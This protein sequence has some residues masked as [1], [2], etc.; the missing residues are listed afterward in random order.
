MIA[1]KACIHKAI[2]DV[3]DQFPDMIIL[4]LS[5]IE[6]SMPSS[7]H[8]NWVNAHGVI[9]VKCNCNSLQ[10]ADDFQTQMI[11]QGTMCRDMHNLDH[12]KVEVIHGID[13]NHSLFIWISYI[14]KA[15]GNKLTKKEMVVYRDHVYGIMTRA[16]IGM[17]GNAFDQLCILHKKTRC[18]ID[19]D[20]CINCF[21]HSHLWWC[22]LF[23]YSNSCPPSSMD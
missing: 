2:C 11:D 7:E 15:D 5:K 18:P 12:T 8:P 9:I 13:R 22:V 14:F 19:G 1:L 6:V 3:N 17:V 21:K 4:V 16:G 23:T 20:D 10:F